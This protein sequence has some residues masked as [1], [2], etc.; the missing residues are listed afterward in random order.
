MSFI[1]SIFSVAFFSFL[2]IPFIKGAGKSYVAFF[3]ILSNA[4][5]SSLLI[6]PELNDTAIE[7]NFYGSNIFGN[8]PIRIDSLSAWFILIINFTCVTGSLYGIGYMKPYI[9]QKGNTSLHWMMFILFHIS[10]I[11]VCMIQNSLAFLIAWELRK[12]KR[13]GTNGTDWD[14]WD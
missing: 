13:K 2:L 3:V 5:L 1:I 8:I 10:M 6:F 9:N 12:V 7:L 14:F 4:I 11:T